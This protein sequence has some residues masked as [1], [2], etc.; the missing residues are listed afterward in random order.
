MGIAEERAADLVE[1]YGLERVS[2]VLDYVGGSPYAVKN[3]AGLVLA[4]LRG[5]YSLSGTVTKSAAGELLDGQRARCV[6][7]CN[8]SLGEC[9]SEEHGVPVYPWCRGCERA[10]PVAP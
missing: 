8:S 1:K 3:P 4:A 10:V 5:N 6:F 7:R 2:K 9:P